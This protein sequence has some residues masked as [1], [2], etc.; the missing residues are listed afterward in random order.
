MNFK[1]FLSI[2]LLSLIVYSCGSQPQRTTSTTPKKTTEIST[3]SKTTTTQPKKEKEE[4]NIIVSL[5]NINREFRAVWVASVANINW[6]SKNNL[7]TAEQKS[8]AIKILD[9]VKNHHLNA[10]IL[11][12]RPSADALYKSN[13]EPWS[14]FLT[15]ETGKAP[16]PYYD[17]LEFWIEEAHNRGIELHIWLNPYR[18]HHTN[19]GSVSSK[20]TLNNTK[21]NVVKLRNGMHWFDPS[22]K[23]TQEHT[24]NVVMDLVK[25]Y[26]IDGVHFDDYFYPYVSYNGGKDFPDDKTWNAYKNRGGKLS[27][28]DWRRHNVNQFVENI[29]KKIKAEKNY[30]KFGISP[31]GIW[32]PGYP[33]G[34]TGS[35]QYD[36]LY[37]DAKLWLNKGWIDYFAPQL[38][39]NI[40]SK[41]Q[42]FPKLLDWWKQENT[43]NRHLWP[44]LNTV[45]V[46]T[47]VARHT[48]IINQIKIS[49]ETLKGSE[50]VIHW[51]LAGLTNSGEMKNAIKN[52]Y[53]E[54]ALVPQTPWLKTDKADKPN[55]SYAHTHGNI[56]IQWNSTSM[57][58]IF[59]WVL[60]LKY[61]ETWETHILD[62]N[63]KSYHAPKRKNHKTLD[64]IAIK[65]IDRLSN[66]SE[67][68]AKKIK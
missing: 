40:D 2:T 63:T 23:A 55:I 44:G 12:V 64:I 29:Y 17:P 31:F 24:T 51:S 65:S 20:A 26:D 60:F 45:A 54:K 68:D 3:E 49:R 42:S 67:Y 56:D 39:W 6:P 22:D 21:A 30:V 53:S 66:E 15:G 19:G 47:P 7:S 33:S 28:A 4:E 50:G 62:K 14:Y 5:P 48:E 32:K 37:A 58:K 27:R 57:N 16:S 10:V 35:S 1:S 13:L 46:R 11:Q 59:Q 38:Y 18:A 52:I 43:Q 61:G 34:I 41:G 9:F 36:E 25:R 8:E